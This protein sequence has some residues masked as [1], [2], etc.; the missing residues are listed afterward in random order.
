MTNGGASE[1]DEGVSPMAG[2]RGASSQLMR[3]IHRW[4]IRFLFDA[5][6]RLGILKNTDAMDAKKISFRSLT[7]DDV[8]LF[9]LDNDFHQA[10]KNGQFI[11][12]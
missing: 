9:Y 1:G 5:E 7:A 11:M 2:A 12:I 4:D 3:S 8:G 6:Q 10:M